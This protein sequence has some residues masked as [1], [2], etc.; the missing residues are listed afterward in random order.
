MGTRW[1]CLGGN[2]TLEDNEQTMKKATGEYLSTR[3]TPSLRGREV[4]GFE[5][6]FHEQGEKISSGHLEKLSL[7]VLVRNVC[8]FGET[9]SLRFDK[10]LE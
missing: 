7:G 3:F 4:R 1:E 8:E 2:S 5:C 10:K 6:I 9:S